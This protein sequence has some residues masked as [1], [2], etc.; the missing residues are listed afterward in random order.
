MAKVK[1]FKAIYYVAVEN[2]KFEEWVEFVTECGAQ[3]EK[4]ESNTC[5]LYIRGSR[6][7]INLFSANLDYEPET[8]EAA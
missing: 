5:K 6:A 8:I 7:A 1:M 2:L 4:L 3:F